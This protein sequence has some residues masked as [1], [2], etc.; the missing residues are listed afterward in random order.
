MGRLEIPQFNIGKV[1]NHSD[2][3]ITRIYNQHQYDQQKRQALEVWEAE[4][5][6][7]AAGKD[8]DS[9]VVPMRRTEG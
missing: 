8:K 5:L 4:L 9:N 6:A 1:L 3:S 7:I 2:Q